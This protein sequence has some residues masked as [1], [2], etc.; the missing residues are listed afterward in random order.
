MSVITLTQL[1]TFSGDEDIIQM[2]MSLTMMPG[3]LILTTLGYRVSDYGGFL[4]AFIVSILFWTLIG[5]I[6]GY[7]YDRMR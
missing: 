5:A 3:Y 4:E 1:G 2:L 7:I 6:I